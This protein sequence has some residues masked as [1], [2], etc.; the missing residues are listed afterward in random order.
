VGNVRGDSQVALVTLSLG[1]LD[2]CTDGRN[3][4]IL[5][6]IIKSKYSLLNK[7]ND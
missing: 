4:Q 2:R 7:K 3:S 6:G 5:G 1:I